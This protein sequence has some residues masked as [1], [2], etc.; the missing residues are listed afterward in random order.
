MSAGWSFF[1]KLPLTVKAAQLTAEMFGYGNSVYLPPSLFTH[2]RIYEGKE[3]WLYLKTLDG[4]IKLSIGDWIIVGI[5]GELY[6]CK[7]EIFKATYEA[8]P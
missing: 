8:I 3:G 1:R 4:P 7:P 2:P 6:P 5:D